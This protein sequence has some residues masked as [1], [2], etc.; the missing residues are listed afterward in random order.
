MKRQLIFKYENDKYILQEEGQTVFSIDGRALKFVSLDFYTGVYKDK[1]AAIQLTN[2]VTDDELKKGN[3]IFAW[4]NEI[5]TAIQEELKE[6]EMEEVLDAVP[7][8]LVYLFELTACAGNGFYCDGPSEGT[9]KI[10]SPYPSADF[11]VRISGKSMEPTIDD[12]SIVFVQ[13]NAELH[14]GDIG[15]F[16]ID[17]EVMCKRYREE[18]QKRWLQPDNTSN[19]YNSIF[20]TE[21]TVCYPQGKVLF[22]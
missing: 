12:N 11:A 13:A 20:L 3:Y 15:I 19:E 7:E 8:N 18:G 16:I 10:P 4:L 1:S 14:D 21:N 5:I 2:A 6:P 17:G 22:S 9:E